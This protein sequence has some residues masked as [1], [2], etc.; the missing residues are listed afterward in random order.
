MHTTDLQSAVIARL[1]N[2]CQSRNWAGNDPYDGLNSRVFRAC[3]FLHYRYPRLLLIQALKRSPINFRPL[4]RVPE[5]QNPKGIALFLM[6]SLRLHEAGLLPG[7]EPARNLSSRLL[8]LNALASGCAGWG[9]NFDWQTR[10][11][12]VP[13]NAPNIICSTFAGNALLDAFRHIQNP[14][15]LT[16]AEDAGR[17]LM[18]HLFY[19][20]GGDVCFSYYPL[21]RTTIHN[22]NLLGAAFIA[23]AGRQLGKP[24]WIDSALKAARYSVRHQHD[25]GSWDYGECDRPSQRWIDNFH[26]GYNL[27]ALHQIATSAETSEFSSSIQRGFEFFRSRFFEADGA[28]KYYHDA[29]YPIDIHSSAQSIITLAYFQPSAPGKS[30]ISRSGVFLDHEIYVERLRIFL[31]SE[32]SLLDNQNAL[33]E[34]ESGMDAVGAGCPAAEQNR[35]Q[36][37][38]MSDIPRLE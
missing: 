36:W 12:L 21:E 9:Y 13:R 22:A 24:E 11:I 31:F 2:Y 38:G 29:L 28:P 4:L 30:E 19:K 7:L 1:W 5:E 15:Y 8:K 3:R 27:C 26:T 35:R 25:D 32:I 33:Y 14:E 6:A 37:H 18:Q 20:N 16:K 10:K 34:M 17:F 23:R